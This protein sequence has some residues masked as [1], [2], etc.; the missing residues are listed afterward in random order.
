VVERE[1]EHEWFGSTKRLRLRGVYKVAAGFDLT[2]PFD[3]RVEGRK[4]LVE[5]PPPKLLSVEQVSAEVLSYENGFWN[6]ISPEDIGVELGRLP[7][8]AR[9]QAKAKGML[10]EAVQSIRKQLTEKFGPAYDVEVQVRGTAEG[11]T[12]QKP[13]V[14]IE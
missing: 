8:E 14:P 7:T 12:E 6:R 5:M 1:R 9:A 4:V 2:Q 13:E 11:L 10:D 3:V